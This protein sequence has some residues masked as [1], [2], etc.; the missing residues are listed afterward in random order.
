MPAVDSPDPG[1]LLPDELAALLRP[2]ASRSPALRRPQHHHLR[3]RPGPRGHGRRAAHRH[4]RGRLRRRRPGDRGQASDLAGR[5]R[6]ATTP[7]A[8]RREPSRRRCGPRTRRPTPSGCIAIRLR[9]TGVGTGPA[10]TLGA[11][12]V[13]SRWASSTSLTAM[14]ADDLAQHLQLGLGAAHQQE[15]ADRGHLDPAALEAEGRRPPGA[16][17]RRPRPPGRR[18]RYAAWFPE[19]P[20]A[21]G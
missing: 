18:R 3:P 11:H 10:M 6:G 21:R 5:E 16:R 7:D 4:R 9:P 1:G 8:P 14:V 20:C 15:A 12:R 19:S 13:S 17:R 2:V